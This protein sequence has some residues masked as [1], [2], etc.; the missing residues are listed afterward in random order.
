MLDESLYNV[1]LPRSYL[2]LLPKNMFTNIRVLWNIWKHEGLIGKSNKH[3]SEKVVKFWQKVM[4]RTYYKE[5]LSDV[6]K[7]GITYADVVG[8]QTQKSEI[9]FPTTPTDP[10]TY[11]IS[12]FA[13][14]N[15][16]LSILFSLY[17]FVSN[18]PIWIFL[19][20]C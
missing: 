12:S 19:Y 9:M 4:K 20:L 3:P 6:L 14:I 17:P 8:R 15:Y 1:I 11:L 10:T 16:T 18:L 13:F 2:F 7:K 5:H